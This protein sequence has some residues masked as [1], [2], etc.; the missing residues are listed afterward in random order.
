MA[1]FQSEKVDDVCG[2]D[3]FFI[4]VTVPEIKWVARFMV[5]GTTTLEECLQ[6]VATETN[7]D[8]E[9]L[10]CR[11]GSPLDE[12]SSLPSLLTDGSGTVE[13][14]IIEVKARNRCHCHALRV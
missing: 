13:I 14:R 10:R 3:R 11:F 4:A 1:V 2:A 7:L 6:L 9:R 5:L 12:L 8:R